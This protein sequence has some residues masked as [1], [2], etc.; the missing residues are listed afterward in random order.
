[1]TINDI[2]TL[3]SAQKDSHYRSHYY[4]IDKLKVSLCWEKFSSYFALCQPNNIANTAISLN[5]KYSSARSSK[6][7]AFDE[8]LNEGLSERM[9]Q[10]RPDGLHVTVARRSE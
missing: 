9:Q 5:W 4:A 3:L 1:M 8:T 10:C 6:S 2:P 7:R